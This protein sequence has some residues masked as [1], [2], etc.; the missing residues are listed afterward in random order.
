MDSV[1][2]PTIPIAAEQ[3]T[4]ARSKLRT[5]VRRKSCG[6]R[7]GTP[8]GINLFSQLF[9]KALSDPEW[10][11]ASYPCAVTGV[12]SAEELEQIRR[13][14]TASQFDQE[15]NCSFTASSDNNLIP[16]DDV[17]AAMQRD[18]LHPQFYQFAPKVLGID[19]AHQ[20][21]DRC[22]MFPRQGLQAFAPVGM[23][24]ETGLP[25]GTV[26]KF[27]HARVDALLAERR[28]QPVDLVRAAALEEESRRELREQYGSDRAEKLLEATVAFIAKHPRLKE[29][30]ETSNLG[31]SAATK[32]AMS[33]LI[34]HVRREGY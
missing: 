5:A 31:A 18:L 12:L 13:E 11:A 8:K 4:P 26:G 30:L 9:H 33:D 6:I 21:G 3:S 19:V 27:F 16:I 32:E 2:W 25:P 34:D 14:T 29:L 17:H 15:M 1:L 23:Q 10:Y 20:G 28:G 24:R 22:V 7:P